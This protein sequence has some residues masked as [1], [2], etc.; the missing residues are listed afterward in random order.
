MRLKTNHWLAIG[1]IVLSAAWLISGIIF[2]FGGDEAEIEEE[3]EVLRVV[4]QTLDYQPIPGGV[5]ISGRTEANYAAT[6][7]ARTNGIVIDMPV[8]EGETVTQGQVIARLSDE[9]RSE[10]V[11]EAQ[12]RLEQAQASY[13]ASAELAEQGF[14]PRLELE[15]RRA[16]QAAA[17]AA[18]DRAQAEAARNLIEA[19][20]SGVLDRLLVDPGEAV[21]Q[22]TEVASIVD[23]DPI[24]AVAG[25]SDAERPLARIGDPA[26]V[27]LQDGRELEGFVRYVASSADQA[28]ATYRMEVEI[29]NPDSS[30]TAGQI[31]DIRL[32]G[33]GA[34]AAK[35]VRSAVTL[36]ENGVIGVKYVGNDGRVE[37]APVQIVQDDPQGLWISGPPEGARVIVRGQEFA[38]AGTRVEPVAAAQLGASVGTDAL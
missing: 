11:R 10:A 12:A 35:I 24:V 26:I 29:A 7:Q 38:N 14:F 30:V 4:V 17:Q 31:A 16:E 19:P 13:Q 20:V 5:S 32:A 8:A 34:S 9:A 36:D 33:S 1:V 6:A 27:R 22:G 25:I 37:F 2:D 28:T 23:L 3:P 15:A 18:L 21:S